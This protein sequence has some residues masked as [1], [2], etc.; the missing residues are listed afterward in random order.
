MRLATLRRSRKTPGLPGLVGVARVGSTQPS[1]DHLAAR[2]L[3]KRLR[4]GD[5]AVIDHLDLDKVTAQ[6]LV[7][8]G[9]SAIVN[10]APSSSGRYPNLGP[11]IVVASG[12]I[13]LDRV[14]AEAIRAIDDGETLR[15]DGNTLYRD[16]TPLAQGDLLTQETVHEAMDR[17]RDGLAFQLQMFASN[18]V[19]HLRQESDLL[20]DGA[21]FP[22]VRTTI[23]GRPVVVVVKGPGWRED[24]A[25]LRHYIGEVSP[26]L[27]GVDEG[28]DALLEA[29]HRPD[30]I[31][32]DLDT[33]SDAALTS[34]AE[35]V[36]HI[37][38]DGRAPGY[39]RL[40]EM[41]AQY[42]PFPAT[43]AGE[44]L[45]LLLADASGADLIVLAG[46]HATLT[47]FIDHARSEM[48]GAFLAR[49][50][51]GSKL[52]DA[53]SIAKLYRHRVATWPLFLVLVLAVA[54][55]VAAVTYT[56]VHGFEG[57][58]LADWWDATVTWARGL[59]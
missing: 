52:V 28:A 44:D 3:A 51:V 43:G 14:G 12:V 19:E 41:G 7:A 59:V 54:G 6:L 24:V 30:I 42:T 46:S 33:V 17:A 39:T 26:V 9:V 15:L 57:T 48:A 49:L 23:D 8:S 25:G 20:L 58:Q 31:I 21:G 5:I 27:I 13:L 35:L 36:L 47:E 38:R 2:D 11:E 10:A 37:S 1:G 18:T 16:E 40:E 22:E 34:G 53:R 56:G 4:P 45:A 50:R 55:L 32:G 29:G